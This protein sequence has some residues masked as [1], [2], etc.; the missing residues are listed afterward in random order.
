MSHTDTDAGEERASRAPTEADRDDAGVHGERREYRTGS[1]SRRIPWRAVAELLVVLGTNLYW[2]L[3]YRTTRRALTTSRDWDAGTFETDGAG[4]VGAATARRALLK[5]TA[6]V[7][8]VPIE[9]VPEQFERLQDRIATQEKRNA[10]LRETA[11][12][13]WWRGLE[14]GT[15]RTQDGL[16]VPIYLADLPEA[17]HEV[18]RQVAIQAVEHDRGVVVAVGRG[19]GSLSVGVGGTLSETISAVEVAREVLAPVEGSAG[20]SDELANGGGGDAEAIAV[21]AH[22]VVER[23]RDEV[24]ADNL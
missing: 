10:E 9:E 16:Q 13:T 12:R 23:I 20:G 2:Y 19:D 6:D 4:S 15:T 14:A 18:A 5:T 1:R 24:R 21:S 7:A 22:E 11:A 8:N 3:R 17:D